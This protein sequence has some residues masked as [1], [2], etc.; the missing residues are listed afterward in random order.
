MNNNNSS[1]QSLLAICQQLH[2]KGIKPTASLIRAKATFQVD[3]AQAISAVR[4]FQ[5]GIEPAAVKQPEVVLDPVERITQL[6]QRVAELEAKML[7][8]ENILADSE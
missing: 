8:L 2:D 4:T 1:T 5:S 6:E 3:I 7:K